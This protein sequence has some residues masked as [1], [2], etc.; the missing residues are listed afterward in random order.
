MGEPKTDVGSRGLFAKLLR[1]IIDTMKHMISYAQ[2]AE[3]VLLR[4]A[5]KNKTRGFYVDVGA[6]DPVKDSV[7]KHFYDLGWNGINI[8]P[9]PDM[10]NKLCSERPRDINLQ[11]AIA[12]QPG[13][14]EFN[15][16]T[17]DS[18]L[19]T[20]DKNVALMHKSNG[21][22]F[23]TIKVNLL[24]LGDVLNQYAKSKLIDFLKIDVEGNEGEVLSSFSFDKW[25]PTVIVIESTIPNTQVRSNEKWEAMVTAHG[26]RLALFDGLNGYYVKND[27]LFNLLNLPA[28]SFD[29]YI[30]YRW[31][32]LMSTEAQELAVKELT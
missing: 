21:L 7:T 1:D 5:F 3:D 32:E 27:K 2:N 6:S 28:S 12:K 9:V 4:R 17:T 22:K 8:E 30:P 26:Y 10:Y 14:G 15:V 31:Y 18:V 24:P 19:S 20:L 16:F 23:E 11:L 13:S 25:E 29:N